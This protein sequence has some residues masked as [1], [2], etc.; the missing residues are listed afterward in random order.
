M[1]EFSIMWPAFVPPLELAESLSLVDTRQTALGSSQRP[2]FY[3]FA[4]RQRRHGHHLPGH[5]G[6]HQREHASQEASQ[7]Q[8]LSRGS[9]HAEGRSGGWADRPAALGD[10]RSRSHRRCAAA[11]DT[12]PR[13]PQGGGQH[14][15]PAGADCCR[16]GWRPD[17]PGCP[18]AV[19]PRSAGGYRRPARGVLRS[20]GVGLTTS[21][22]I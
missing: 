1:T 16:R 10:R 14:W 13:Q 17:L 20:G 19:G 8:G 22:P 4:P 2:L 12:Q 15:H 6:Q 21:P 9:G 3:L 11:G 5:S 7:G 18:P